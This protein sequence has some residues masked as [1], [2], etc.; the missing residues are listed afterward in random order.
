MSSS[1]LDALNREQGQ[2]GNLQPGERFSMAGGGKSIKAIF[3]MA[4]N[5][6]VCAN[7]SLKL[8]RRAVCVQDFPDAI[9]YIR[10][11]SPQTGLMPTCPR[12]GG[13]R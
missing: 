10:P 2:L 7:Y 13:R 3:A 9:R 1:L 6:N 8:T 5:R 11:C 12:R 4:G